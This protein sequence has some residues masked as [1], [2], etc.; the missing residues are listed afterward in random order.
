M[1]NRVRVRVRVIILTDSN[2]EYPIQKLI[3]SS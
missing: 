1:V 2:G 3:L